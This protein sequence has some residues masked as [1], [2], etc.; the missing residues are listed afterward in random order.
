MGPVRVVVIDV[1]DDESFELVLVPDGD[2]PRP[3]P[4]SPCSQ[5]P[6]FQAPFPAD[7]AA[8]SLHDLGTGRKQVRALVGA[9]DALDGVGQASLGDLA[10]HALLSGPGPERGAHAVGG[11]VDAEFA[12]QLRERLIRQRPTGGRGREHQP[13]AVAEAAGLS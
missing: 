5:S 9:L 11:A 4:Q 1:V 3:S 10:A 12:H 6:Q 2:T 8:L 7:I 13:V